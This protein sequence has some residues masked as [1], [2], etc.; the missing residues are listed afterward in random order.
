MT[1]IAVTG[2]MDLT[3]ASVPLVRAALLELLKPYA[4]ERLTSVSCIA[5]GADSLFAEA[6]LE[7]GGR[8]VAVIPSQDYRQSKVNPDHASTFDWL[9]EAAD[10]VLVLP[11]ETANRSAYEDANR[12]LL[13]RA[14]RLVAVW[15]GEPPS[16]KGGGTA[17][18]VMEARATGLPVDVVWPEG[19]ARRS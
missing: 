2:H 12:T 6:V 19:V 15:D 7:V 11:H 18:T 17:D 8:M 5:K 4:A 1:T 16:G 14:D 3:D 10:E 9:I 13:K